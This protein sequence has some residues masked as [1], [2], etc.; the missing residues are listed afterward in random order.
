MPPVH[1]PRQPPYKRRSKPHRPS[2]VSFLLLAPLLIALCITPLNSTLPLP[3][4]FA[5]RP[6]PCLLHP[7]WPLVR[8]S[9]I[10]S[11]FSL[12]RGKPPWP[13][14][15]ARHNSVEPLSWP[16]PWST[17]DQR[18]PWS[19]KYGPSPPHFQY[20]INYKITGKIQDL[21]KNAPCTSNEFHFYPYI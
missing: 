17:V 12:C 6:N 13:G 18:R 16:C 11:P 7:C 8:N 21:C 3:F 1:S 10:R 14:V 15:A 19:T 5:D 9:E 4:L 20:E 2:C